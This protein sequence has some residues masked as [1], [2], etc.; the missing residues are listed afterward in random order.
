MTIDTDPVTHA[1]RDGNYDGRDPALP[2]TRVRPTPVPPAFC[3]I[4]D[5][6]KYDHS[7]L[8]VPELSEDGEDD[9]ATCRAIAVATRQMGLYRE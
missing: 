4:P 2:R 8:P 9:R 7:S 3:D 6:L 5:E 1:L